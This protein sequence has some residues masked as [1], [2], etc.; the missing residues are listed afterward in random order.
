MVNAIQVTFLNGDKKIFVEG[1]EFYRCS[2]EAE[3][4]VLTTIESD[5]CTRWVR[6]DELYKPVHS[7]LTNIEGSINF[8][9]P[10]FLCDELRKEPSMFIICKEHGVITKP[11]AKPVQ[12][13]A[14][15]KQVGGGHYKN[16]KIQP[17]E[18]V[19]AN[20]I[21]FVEGNVIKYVSRWKFKNGVQDLE[22][23]KHFLE[24]LIEDASK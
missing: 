2:P 7:Q 9:N 22:K 11:P 20:D 10:F 23:A 16:L 21:G 19:L 1:D 13:A 8:H 4:Y 15:D 24:I 6:L 14:L 5:G 3:V 17:I 18:Y 12:P